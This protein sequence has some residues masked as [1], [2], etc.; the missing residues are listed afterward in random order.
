M[1]YSDVKRKLKV[2]DMMLTMH[3]ILRIR[4]QRRAM[5]LEIGLV[6]ASSILLAL[7]FIDSSALQALG[8]Q[9]IEASLTISMCSVLVFILSIVAL[10]VDWKGKAQQHADASNA[11]STLKSDWHEFLTFFDNYDDRD[12]SELT[13][14]SALVLSSLAPIPESKFNRL[15]AR[16]HKKVLL[17]KMI[18]LYP[19]GSVSFLSACLWFRINK[20]VISCQSEREQN[21]DNNE[22]SA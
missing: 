20:K 9:P 22:P 6:S 18:S 4:F 3:S 2:V 14:R 19:G 1:T 10:I 8:I 5:I 11:L 12:K 16:H 7:T 15:K 13:K 21:H 17:S